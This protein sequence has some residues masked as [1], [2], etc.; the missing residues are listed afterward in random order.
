MVQRQ[1]EQAVAFDEAFDPAEERRLAKK[2]QQQQRAEEEKKA[3]ARRLEDDEA[4]E[5][6]EVEEVDEEEFVEEELP[7]ASASA[8]ATRTAAAEEDHRSYHSTRASSGSVQQQQQQQQHRQPQRSRMAIEHDEYEEDD[9]EGGS[10]DPNDVPVDLDPRARVA[11]PLPPRSEWELSPPPPPA[12]RAMPI[13]QLRPQFKFYTLEADETQEEA[14]ASA[15]NAAVQVDQIPSAGATSGNGAGAAPRRFGLTVLLKAHTMG[16]LRMLRAS[17]E[18]LNAVN[19]ARGLPEIHVAL[20][21]VGE[22]S[23]KDL[24]NAEAEGCWI[25]VFRGAKPA[26]TLLQHARARGVPLLS[27]RH[28]QHLLDHLQKHIEQ[29]PVLT[30]S[31]EAKDVLDQSASSSRRSH[32]T[33]Q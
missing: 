17:V 19:I 28:H 25:Y 20:A 13:A 3:R 15:R 9:D 2:L 8:P 1:T 27:F 26:K 18:D 10:I 5:F 16:A 23:K 7:E 11:P 24:V 6:D 21:A 33:V 29:S 31:G 14:D 12:S 32:Y 4:E 30:R 22:L